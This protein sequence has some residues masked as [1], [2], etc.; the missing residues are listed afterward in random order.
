MSV[1][2]ALTLWKSTRSSLWSLCSP[3]HGFCSY[4]ETQPWK[5]LEDLAF[6]ILAFSSEA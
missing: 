2:G 4:A 6:G 1:L 5:V 3:I